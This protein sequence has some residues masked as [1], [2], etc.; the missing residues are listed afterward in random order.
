[1]GRRPQPPGLGQ[2]ELELLR[3]VTEHAPVT[4]RE[5]ADHVARTKGQA[6]TTALTVMERLRQKGFLTRKKEGGLYRYSASVPQ[7]D[8][9][10]RLVR[11]FVE[12]SL[13][14]SLAP[15]VAYL[16]SDAAV[17]EGELAELKQIVR[18]LD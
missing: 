16:A 6:R 17:S 11:E 10:R 8:L 14:G 1:M 7:A 3:Y 18:D 4:V 13:G 15:F 9:L 2:A 5:V 12:R